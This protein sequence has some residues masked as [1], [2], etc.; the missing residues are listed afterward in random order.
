MSISTEIGKAQLSLS[1]TSKTQRPSYDDLDGTVSYVN[2]LTLEGGN[3]YLSP[4]KIHTVE[5]MGA[6]KQFFAKVSYEHRKDAIIQT[7][8]SYG[9]DGEVK[10]LTMENTQKIDELQAFVGAQ[11][12]VGIWEPKVNAGITKQW[13]AGEF[14]GERK[15][16]G[17][18]MAIVQF[19]N[20]IHLPGDIWANID[21]E[22]TSRG[23][24]DNMRLSSSSYLNAKLYKAFCNN[25]LSVSL[26]A[27]DIFN[28]STRDVVFY[29]KDVTYW[30]NMTSDS[31]ALLL[32]LQYNFNTS[33]NRYKGKGA[34]NEELN[35]F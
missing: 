35:R 4:M 22:W 34:G 29:N 11:F 12:K 7:T 3:P 6:W 26:Q 19:Q 15:S 31:R 10:L 28:K 9:E 13:F 27:D 33:R 14:L 17:N 23:N 30:Q 21:M 24:K 1:Y 8:K 18:P 2:R 16:F 32:T 25:C 20:A 5:L